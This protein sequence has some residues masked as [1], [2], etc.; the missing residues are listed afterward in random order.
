M[1]QYRFQ[2]PHEDLPFTGERYV[3]N[4]RDQ[5][6]H[7]HFHRYLLAAPLCGGKD[8]LDVA[9]GEGY[10]SAL[11]ATVARSVVGVDNSEEAISHAVASY[12]E[13]RNVAFKIADVS[14]VIPL[15]S[16]SVDIIVSFETLE[17]LDEQEAFIAECRRV[18]R[19]EG[20]LLL[21]TPNSEVYLGGEGTNEFHKREL[22]R[23]ELAELLGATFASVVI[24]GQQSDVGSLIDLRSLDEL[25]PPLYF[26]RESDEVFN[27]GGDL[28]DPTFFVAVA[29]DGPL[30]HIGFST[31]LDPGFRGN[32][33]EAHRTALT[34]AWEAHQKALATHQEA[35][36]IHQEVVAA[37]QEALAALRSEFDAER[38]RAEAER[39]AIQVLD[40]ELVS[41]RNSISWRITAPLRSAKLFALKARRHG[42]RRRLTTEQGKLAAPAIPRLASSADLR[43]RPLI[44]V[45]TPVYNTDPRWLMRVVESVRAQSYSRW[46]LCI[47][48]DG[49]TSGRTRRALSDLADDPSIR[50]VR[51][52]SNGGISVASNRA[53]EL[54]Q[55]DFVAFLDHDDELAPEALLECVC[56]LNEK[57]DTD[58][59]YTDEDKVDRRGWHSTPFHKP[60][61]SPELFRGVM[62]V[63]HL[64]VVRRS[65]V[66]E[67]GGFNSAFDGVQDY[68]LML[69]LSERTA[70]I[71]HV[72]RILYHWRKVPGSVASST[73]AKPGISALQAA[74]VNAHL[75]RCSIEAQAQPHPK[76]PHRVVMYPKP[77]NDWPSVD[78]VIPTKDAPDHIGRCLDSLYGRTTYPKFQVYVVD[79]ATTDPDAL[80]AILGSGATVVPFEEPFNFSR[81]INSGVAAGGGD[82]VVLLN[83]DTEVVTQDWL[84]SM[85]WV[86]ELPDVGAVAPLLI[87]PN[88]TV[89]H[90][91]VVLGMRGTADH[92]MRGY[93]ADADGYAGSLACAREVS[94]VTGACMLV[95]RS[96]FHDLGHLDVHFATHY[97]DVDFCLKI[98]QKGLRNVFTPRS[99]L[100]HHESASRGSHY[101]QLDRALLLDRWGDTIARG[102]PYYNPWLSLDGSDYRVRSRAA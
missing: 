32:L 90:A 77:R 48:D 6:Q 54:A 97:Q 9:C 59:V 96:L 10:G 19:S 100:I 1:P 14:K 52:E 44:S 43:V 58:V 45:I 71:E 93:P 64:L 62:Y 27:P 42:R 51:N 102:D 33:D 85:V 55:G 37:Q 34:E 50:I 4:L 26:V 39:N 17:H 72:P 89:Q 91:G 18:L 3:P 38:A 41:V 69:R 79:N 16:G 35:V 30:P 68:E 98:R 67:V 22:S 65:L 61:W 82:F 60:D 99:V 86:A 12:G 101:D 5:I 75:N 15:D 70:R 73:D 40:A 81:A 88:G 53:L 20:V 94:V 76:L 8:V 84:E 13:A 56:V 29:S 74:A 57:P 11:L 28:V 36:A 66:D 49:S 87:Y 24:G 2:Q 25:A 63:G 80:R 46:E 7:E 78:I 92:I 23:S 21:S 83:N 47:C 95:R 31:L